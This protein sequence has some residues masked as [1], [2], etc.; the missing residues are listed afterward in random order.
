MKRMVVAAALAK[1]TAKAVGG[2]IVAIQGGNNMKR[3]MMI[4]AALAA[5]AGAFAW[6]RPNYTPPADLRDA[7]AD[8]GEFNTSLP[9]INKNAGNI[10]E[11]GAAAV[12][13]VIIEWVLIPKGKFRMGTDA[14]DKET[15]GN[16][17]PV[18]EVS[19]NAFEMSR[20]LVT[21]TQYAECVK[22]GKC[23]EP[24]E[25]CNWGDPER[26]QYPVNCVH[27]GNA[28]QYAKFAATRPGTEGARLPTE[29]EWEY[30]ATSA[31]K[32][33]EHPWGNREMT[34]DRET[35]NCGTAQVCSRPEGNTEQ[36]LCDMIGNLYQWVQD[37]FHDSYTGA[38]SDG[39]AFA[40]NGALR[41]MRGGYYLLDSDG[42]YR[43]DSRY[44]RSSLHY[45][46]RDDYGIRLARD[47]K[48][49]NG[50]R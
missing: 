3:N 41:V 22:A 27:W 11:P 23:E 19:I 18:H 28:V 10:P 34:C 36:G 40:G 20:T 7:V 49:V 37:I 35:G 29:A 46:Y 2:S 30:A 42:H 15:Y 8:S 33:P 16:A 6:T 25:A 21:V 14:P 9:A 31:G 44:R 24:P 17:K 43:S 1:D 12:P 39:G 38:P 45:R 50:Y 13:P 48:Q 5:A 47:A 32:E 26:R 4:V